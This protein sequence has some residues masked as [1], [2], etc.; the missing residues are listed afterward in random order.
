M[1]EEKRVVKF[2]KWLAPKGD[3]FLTVILDALEVLQYI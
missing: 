3:T 2:Q 1:K